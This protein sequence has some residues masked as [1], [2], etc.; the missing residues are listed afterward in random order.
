MEKLT[1]DPDTID[2]NDIQAARTGGLSA[3]AI[4]DAVYVCGLFNAIDRIADALSFD[5]PPAEAHRRA[6]RFL[7]RR[8]YRMPA[9]LA[10]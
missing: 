5:L 4:V 7:L 6:S 1:L 2:P 8:G 10:R 3:E 9:L